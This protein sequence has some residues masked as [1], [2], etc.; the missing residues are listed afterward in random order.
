[1]KCTICKGEGYFK[2][3]DSIINRCSI[4]D[5]SGNITKCR[6]CKGVGTFTRS[7]IS[8]WKIVPCMTCIGNGVVPEKLYHCVA[9][10]NTGIVHNLTILYDEDGGK[11]QLYEKELCECKEGYKY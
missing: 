1:M 3:D 11:D 7:F 9:C 4:C 6:S 2:V 10:N 8:E 5:G